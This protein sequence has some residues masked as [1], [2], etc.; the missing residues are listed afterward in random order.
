VLRLESGP[1][2]AIRSA[3]PKWLLQALEGYPSRRM[4]PNGDLSV[5]VAV[6]LSTAIRVNIDANHIP[7]NGPHVGSLHPQ[8]GTV[9]KA[10][11]R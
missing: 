9:P 4:F 1:P 2:A 6:P 11:R 7:A 10:C 8:P 5:C 3:V